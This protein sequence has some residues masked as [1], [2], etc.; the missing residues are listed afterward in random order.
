MTLSK[1]TP[2]R[3]VYSLRGSLST[4]GLKTVNVPPATQWCMKR[5]EE[6]RGISW[7]NFVERQ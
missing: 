4:G 2:S 1:F 5:E 6:G 3:L 7:R